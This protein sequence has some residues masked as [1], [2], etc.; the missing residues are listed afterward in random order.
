MLWI[1]LLSAAVYHNQNICG[2]WTAIYNLQDKNTSFEDVTMG[3]G[4]LCWV[5][6]YLIIKLTDGK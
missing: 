4:N 2:F 6:F 3:S 5:L 1:W